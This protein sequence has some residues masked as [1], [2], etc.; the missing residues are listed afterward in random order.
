MG[1]NA[2]P[3][4][5]GRSLRKYFR[6]RSW[7]RKVSPIQAVDG[8]S[9]SVEAGEV[10]GIVG[11]SGCGKST[12]ARLLMNLI[13]PDSGEVLFE[14]NPVGTRRLPAKTFRRQAQMVFQDS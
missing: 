7:P 2:T 10:L 13:Q 11:E 1:R 12:L 3:I 5:E 8:V 6:L 9:F 14:G 4:L